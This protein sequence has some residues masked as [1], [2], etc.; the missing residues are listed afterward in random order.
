MRVDDR[1]C[2]N[3]DRNAS[4]H[5]FTPH[6]DLCSPTT[7]HRSRVTPHLPADIGHGIFHIMAGYCY[8]ILTNHVE[9]DFFVIMSI[10]M[11]N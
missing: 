6:S 2:G 4:P 5:L 1:I 8:Q 7:P 3:D 10:N 11:I 9:N